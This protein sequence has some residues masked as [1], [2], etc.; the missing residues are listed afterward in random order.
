MNNISTIST[1]S[2]WNDVD[3]YYGSMI[4]NNTMKEIQTK[5][6]MNKS[7]YEIIRT[8][9]RMLAQLDY[10]YEPMYVTDVVFRYDDKYYILFANIVCLDGINAKYFRKIENI[11]VGL[12]QLDNTNLNIN[13]ADTKV[14]FIMTD[15]NNMDKYEC[16]CKCGYKENPDIY[17]NSIVE[18]R[19]YQSGAHVEN[20]SKNRPISKN[21]EELAYYDD[22]NPKQ[23]LMSD[24]TYLNVIDLSE[25]YNSWHT[26]ILDTNNEH[27]YC[28]DYMALINK[29][30]VPD[31]IF[32]CLCFSMSAHIH[33]YIG[34][35]K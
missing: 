20:V 18:L 35:G 15:R 1:I 32:D 31:D 4:D 28:H 19:Y 33:N 22:P 11:Y 3:L 14:K 13:I 17:N 6:D 12:V 10:Y 16:E 34:S 30:N 26:P 21:H 23:V 7:K 8:N 29:L 2:I 24:G 9:K 27:S 25:K 5:L